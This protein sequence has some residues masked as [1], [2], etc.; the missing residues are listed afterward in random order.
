MNITKNFVDKLK[1][2]PNG[3]AQ[4]RYFDDTMR[5]FGVRITSNGVK[6]FFI[7][8]K[9]S[10]KTYRLTLGQYPA[11]TI[12]TARQLAQEALTKILSGA[13]PTIAKQ[14][15]I[16]PTLQEIF[17]DIMKARKNLS[18]NTIKYYKRII[19]SDLSC[20]GNR[21][22]NTIT[23]EMI[24]NKHTE[25]GIASHTSANLVMR[26]LRA[27]FTF[28]AGNYFDENG[29]SLVIDNPVKVLSH[30]KAWYNESRRSTIITPAQLPV[31]YKAVMMLDQEQPIKATV[32]KD[33]LLLLLFTGLRKQ[34]AATLKW[35]QVDFNNNT[36]TIHV[37]KN[38]ERHVI[39]MPGRT[40]DLLQNRY[41]AASIR[42]KD[43]FVFSGKGRIG[44]ITNMQKHIDRISNSS[45]VAFTLHDLRRTFIT[46]AESL[47]N[48]SAYTLKKLLNHKNGSDVTGGYIVLDV[49]RLR[50]P[51]QRITDRILDIVGSDRAGNSMLATR[52]TML[53]V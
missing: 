39:P 8:K 43:T 31:W 12:D 48:I 21:P 29:K 52:T 47:D 14:P 28:A 22:V 13:D 40:K 6:S 37:T 18:V 45:G 11:I 32:I 10:H 53:A 27:I 41:N 23:I 36:I 34:E 16:I 25:L 9:Y 30:T 38:K 35:S 50:T 51:M 26:V 15:V 4:K 33:Y 19:S 24:A 1:P 20:W 3:M 46:I 5:G 17:I 49:E 42:S 44:C 2:P 7:E